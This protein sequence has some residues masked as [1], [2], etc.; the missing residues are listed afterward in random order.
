MG[1]EKNN[2]LIFFGVN[3]VIKSVFKYPKTVE[4]I[5]DSLLDL[6]RKLKIEENFS[7]GEP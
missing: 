2:K 6:L 3:N 1:K 4:N 5:Y 7:K